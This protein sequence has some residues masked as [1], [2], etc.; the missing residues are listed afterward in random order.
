MVDIFPKDAKEL[1]E[2]FHKYWEQN[3]KADISPME[4]KKEDEKEVKLVKNSPKVKRETKEIETQCD[5]GQ[6][7]E[8]APLAAFSKAELRK[9]KKD[10]RKLKH[11]IWEE[12]QKRRADIKGRNKQMSEKLAEVTTIKD[13]TV[14]NI[15]DLQEHAI[16]AI[17]KEMQT[18][19]NVILFKKM[20]PE[21]SAYK[22]EWYSG[23]VL[24]GYGRHSHLSK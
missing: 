10:K 7:D 3:N 12:A 9:E 14:D 18:E 8:E 20:V 22:Y 23:K 21:A 6:W 5:W 17:S 2:I 11:R 15:L 4:D 19:D 1:V 13:V 16:T 24:S